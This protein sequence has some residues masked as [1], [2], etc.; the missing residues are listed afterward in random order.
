MAEQ[1]T[2]ELNST[3]AIKIDEARREA[4]RYASMN[5]WQKGDSPAS[6]FPHISLT[7][8]A[9]ALEAAEEVRDRAKRFKPRNQF[10]S[11]VVRDADTNA[12]IVS[13]VLNYLHNPDDHRFDAFLDRV[14]G[15]GTYRA[16]LDSVRPQ[17][18]PH[19]LI[20]H[21]TEVKYDLGC[22]SALDPS[23]YM[24]SRT[25]FHSVRN[26]VFEKVKK[27]EKEVAHLLR[28][29]GQ[30]HCLDGLILDLAPADSPFSF[31]D[32]PNFMCAMGLLNIYINRTR[33]GFKILEVPCLSVAVHE[34]AGHAAQWRLTNKYMPQG[35]RAG[36]RE[37][38]SFVHSSSAEGVALETEQFG[39]D[40]MQKNPKLWG[41][42]GQEI[43]DAQL[44]CEAYIPRQ[45][46]QLVYSV[47]G[48]ERMAWED[49]PNMPKIYNLEPATRLSR[50]MGTDTFRK[51]KNGLQDL[52]FD[53]FTQYISYWVGQRRIAPMH[54]KM[55]A[56]GVKPADAY[57]AIQLG[58]WCDPKAQ[59]DFIFNLELPIQG[60]H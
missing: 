58:F 48:F 44:L 42:S 47:F 22:V 39:F 54:Q 20:H 15:E 14:Y 4:N 19:D 40:H 24:G 46:P 55:K 11:L 16:L 8:Q 38:S 25:N 3:D 53:D 30:A 9:K 21:A 56:M 57:R 36:H 7:T 50:L 35:L 52:T 34:L 23:V 18:Y 17:N 5:F 27:R 6:L 43:S 26:R 13:N 10:D 1:K 31:L 49:V 29:L 51:D 32:E 59:E 45:L 37:F 2:W 33:N 41:L 60:Y 12:R 28:D